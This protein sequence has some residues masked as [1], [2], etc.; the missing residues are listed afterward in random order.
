MK[1]IYFLLFLGYGTIQSQ[2]LLEIPKFIRFPLDTK[3]KEIFVED[4]KEL[5][6]D[7]IDSVSEKRIF[8]A[9]KELMLSNLMTK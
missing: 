9:D 4:L 6:S 8:S 3:A 2:E 1:I 5:I 7:P